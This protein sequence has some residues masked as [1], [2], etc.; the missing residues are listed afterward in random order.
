MTPEQAAKLRIQLRRGCFL[1]A[2]REHADLM[3]AQHERN[4]EK[5]LRRASPPVDSARMSTAP[6]RLRRIEQIDACIGIAIALAIGLGLMDWVPAL[7][8]EVI[9]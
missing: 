4:C 5:M 1:P 9:R 3:L 6:T 2:A 8:A 7:L